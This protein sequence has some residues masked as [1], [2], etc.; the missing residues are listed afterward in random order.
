MKICLITSSFARNDADFAAPWLNRLSLECAARGHEMSV[1]APSYRGISQVSYKGEVE[2]KR[3]RYWAAAQERLTHEDSSPASLHTFFYKVL[4]LS[5]LVCGSLAAARLCL[6]RRFDVIE[7]HWPVPQGLFGVIGKLLT[8]ARLSFVF[9]GSE[10]LLLRGSAAGRAGVRFLTRFAD[11]VTA[12][13]TYTKDVL[14]K[15][16][17]VTGPINVIPFGPSMDA[18]EIP[19]P[20]GAAAPGK[21]FTILYVGKLIERKGPQYLVE[22]FSRLSAAGEDMRLVMVGDGYLREEV[23]KQI[24]D[25][26]I[27]DKVT[28]VSGLSRSELDLRYSGC[29]VLVFPSIID[30]RGDTEGLGLAPV[31]ALYHSKPVIA[32]AVGGVLDVIRDGETGYLVPQRDPAALA[33]KILLVKNNYPA[34][35][36]LAAAGR[37]DA[38][39]RFSW[40]TITGKFLQ[41]YSGGGR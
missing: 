23:L 6:F 25:A 5:Y 30:D 15:D 1:L 7:V 29:D 2:L 28:V 3:F 19:P 39:K 33:E 13:S 36:K 18:G 38:L 37:E 27:K 31:E 22:A 21:P 34:A 24:S 14:E 26:K 35:L 16:F 40:E 8:G 41:L 17:G 20:A 10:I 4:L 12:I 32:S 9:Y 11:S